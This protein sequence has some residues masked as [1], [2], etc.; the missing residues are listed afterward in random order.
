VKRAIPLLSLLVGVAGCGSSGGPKGPTIEPARTFELVD[1]EPSGTIQPG[2]ATVAFTLD[3][4]SGRPLTS[5]R[6][7]AGPHTGIHVI[8][9]KDD[10]STIVHRHPPIGANGR[11]SQPIDFPSPG[12]YRVLADIYPR[13][14]G[15]QRNFQLSYDVR[16]AGRSRPKPLPPFAASATV[17]GY[18]VVLHGKPNV[19]AIFPSFFRVTVT[20]PQGRPATFRPWYGA[21]AHAIFFHQ[22]NLSYF[23]T[24]V[25]GSNTLGC[26]STL[27]G[28][29]VTG[30]STNP[31]QLRVGVLLPEAGAWRMFLQF[32]ANGKVLTVP[33]T[34]EA[35]P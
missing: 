28:A 23:H 7:G 16:V 30:S 13:L 24:H 6:T 10:L 33:F 4:P 17:A 1:K 3:Q 35:A 15:P 34:L 32:Q 14:S 22:G 18:R 20:D 5:Y 26:T 2:R 9:V 31:G 11:L 21:L 27:G 12:R 8:V 29:R 25:C 19:R